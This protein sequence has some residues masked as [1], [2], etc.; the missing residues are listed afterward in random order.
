MFAENQ[1]FK[2]V[3]PRWP[4][5]FQ[6]KASEGIELEEADR[7]FQGNVG[8]DSLQVQIARN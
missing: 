3:G 6:Q 7:T 8:S 1:T 4:T 2:F 5:V